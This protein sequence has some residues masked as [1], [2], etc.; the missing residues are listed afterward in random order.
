MTIQQTADEAPDQRASVLSGEF[1]RGYGIGCQHGIE[2]GRQLEAEERDADWLAI[3][4]PIARSGLGHA[5]HERRRWG[6]GGRQHFADPR[7]ADF[8]G[9]GGAA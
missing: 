4:R 8:Q 3:A 2:I 6:P 1:M 9:R 7:P 5:E